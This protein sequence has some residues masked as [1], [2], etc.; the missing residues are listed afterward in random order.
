MQ[1]IRRPRLTLRIIHILRHHSI[2]NIVN[3]LCFGIVITFLL[4]VIIH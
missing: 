2:T 3:L 4:N 1:A